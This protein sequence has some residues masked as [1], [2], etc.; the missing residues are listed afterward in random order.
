MI[1]NFNNLGDS[2]LK[3]KIVEIF[4]IAQKE[5]NTKSNISVNVTIVGKEKIKQLNNEFRKVN[6]VTDVLSFPL[7]E[8]F[9]LHDGEMLD[10]NIC[11]DVG[12]IVI[13]KS[14]AIDQAKEY[15]HSVQREICFLAL[16]GFLHV[17]GYDHIK[18]EDEV[19]MLNLQNKILKKAQVE[20][21]W[22]TN[23]VI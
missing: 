21:W 6:K 17:L 18:R 23:V 12:D 22:N 14:R 5:T 4:N 7:L 1:V 3:Q 2:L 15:G 16:H 20:R 11:T 9:E 10:E 8:I 19:I 13:C